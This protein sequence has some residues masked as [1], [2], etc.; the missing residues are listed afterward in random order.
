MDSGLL[1]PLD[2]AMDL[3]SEVWAHPDAVKA[4]L[5]RGQPDAAKTVHPDAAKTVLV[6]AHPDAAK[7]V[8]VRAHPDAAKTVPK[9]TPA[10]PL[11]QANPWSSDLQSSLEYS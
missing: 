2:L 5:V 10:V 3:G 9:M 6:R 11:K 7:T 4:V 8:L 1:V